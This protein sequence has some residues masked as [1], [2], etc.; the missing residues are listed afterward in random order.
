M[1]YAAVGQDYAISRHAT[2]LHRLYC[3]IE[4]RLGETLFLGGQGYSIADIATFPWLRNQSRRFGPSFPF[5]SFADGYPSTFPH[6]HAWYR[7]ILER[8]AVARAI[9]KFDAI[10][11]TLAQ[12]SPSDLDRVFG[13]GSFAFPSLGVL[14]DGT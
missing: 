2:E 10:P 5:L 6:L 3:V 9:A 7:G 14:A 12:A 8:P 11:S 13:R 1:L 4:G